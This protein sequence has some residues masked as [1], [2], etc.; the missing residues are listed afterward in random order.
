MGLWF[1]LHSVPLS[2]SSDHLV[3]THLDSSVRASTQKTKNLTVQ[4]DGSWRVRRQIWICRLTHG[5]IAITDCSLWPAFYRS[6]L[7]VASG[8]PSQAVMRGARLSEQIKL[9]FR[10]LIA[11]QGQG[12]TTSK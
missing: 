10:G 7:L 12:H 3:F 5:E 6:F 8:A 1:L 4:S 9:S 2:I 11:C